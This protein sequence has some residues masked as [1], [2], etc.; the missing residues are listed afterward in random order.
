MNRG[1]CGRACRNDRRG[2]GVASRLSAQIGRALKSVSTLMACSTPTPHSFAL[3]GSTSSSFPSNSATPAYPP[4]PAT[5]TISSP[6]RSSTLCE[7]GPGRASRRETPGNK[8]IG[9]VPC[10]TVDANAVCLRSAEQSLHLMGMLVLV[11]RL[12]VHLHF[13][14]DQALFL[15]QLRQLHVVAHIYPFLLDVVGQH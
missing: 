9:R 14:A 8:P 15:C 4:P 10:P 5:S 2:Q 12:L 1:I 13:Q 7:V 3:K 11:C 6:A